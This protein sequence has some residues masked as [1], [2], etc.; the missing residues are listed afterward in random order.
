[1]KK[2]ITYIQELNSLLKQDKLDIAKDKMK[3]L[4]KVFPDDEAVPFIETILNA[5]SFEKIEDFNKQKIKTKKVNSEYRSYFYAYILMKDTDRFKNIIQTKLFEGDFFD[6]KYRNPDLKATDGLEFRFQTFFIGFWLLELSIKNMNQL[7]PT[8]NLLFKS[9]FTQR[10]IHTSLLFI[11]NQFDYT[12]YDFE[13]TQREFSKFS[14]L[15][16]HFAEMPLDEIKIKNYFSLED[17]EI[18]D[19]GNKKEIYL[20]GENGDGKTIL[21]Q[22]I[23]LALKGNSGN[24]TIFSY[25][26]QNE[27]FQNRENPELEKKLILSAKLKKLS[28]YEFKTNHKEQ[29]SSYQNIFAYGVN[30]LRKSDKETDKEGYLTL[31]DSD[32]YLTSPM[33]WLKDIQ[34]DFLNYQDKEAKKELSEDDIKP[35]LPEQAKLLLEQVINFEND[36]KKFQINIDG[37]N[38]SFTEKETDLEFEQL[39]DGY[40]S[41]LIL[42]SDLLSHLSKNQ[43]LI[44][45]TPDYSGIVLIDELG[46]FLHP[47]WEFTIARILRKLFPNIQWIYTTHSPIAILGASKE[48]VFYKLYKENGKTR[49]SNPFSPQVFSN[50][51]LSGFVTSP[52]FN[53]PT[54]KPAAYES[55][56]LDFETGDYIY[57]IIHKEVKKRLEKEPLQD[58]EIKNMVRNLLD[59]FEKEVS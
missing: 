52:L 29:K 26:N 47:K 18:T 13:I 6:K 36:K 34:L 55:S 42:L 4:K 45:K 20:L 21:L 2:L 35:I 15:L 1:M 53:M 28:K 56:K 23:L 16:I 57:S 48:A 43:P 49:I 38:I 37:R 22:A 30:R 44:H 10:D 25:I 14:D 8:L 46:V 51:L 54:A 40:K 32:V 24:E 12:W 50:K 9:G 7:Q 19:L 41:I 39:S 11:F 17:I 58:E 31:F 33:Q 59:E 3:E 5:F 27:D